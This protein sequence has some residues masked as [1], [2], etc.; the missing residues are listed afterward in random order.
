MP[1]TTIEL[2]ATDARFERR[3]AK[4]LALWWRRRGVDVNHVITRF[5]TLPADRVYS[6]PFPL[7]DAFALVN[8]L[9]ARDR[10]HTFKR[11][12]ADAVRTA[13]LPAIPPSRVFISFHPTN[14]N[15]HFTP[16]T[17]ED[18]NDPR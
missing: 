8:C 18:G 11:D 6:G 4:D 13:L 16:K 2:P 3:V 10:D 5:V 14:P 12:Y 15:D 17:W 1:T 7:G 9:V